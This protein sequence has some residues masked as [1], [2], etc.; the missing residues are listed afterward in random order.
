M[1]TITSTEFNQNPAKAKKHAIEQPVQ[2][3]TK[4]EVSHVLLSIEE[5]RSL[6]ANSPNIGYRLAMP[7]ITAELELNKLDLSSVKPVKFD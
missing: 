3:T 6:C 2:I 7:E 4:G 1:K 5:Y